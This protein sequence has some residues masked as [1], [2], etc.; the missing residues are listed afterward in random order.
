MTL[1]IMIY[2]YQSYGALYLQDIR[3]KII[4]VRKHGPCH[5][6]TVDKS[7]IPRVIPPEDYIVANQYPATN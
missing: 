3:P 4:S 7:Q 2:G 6:I 5:A 1:M